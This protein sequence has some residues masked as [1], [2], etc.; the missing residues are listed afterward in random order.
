VSSLG[1]FTHFARIKLI[2]GF[3]FSFFGSLFMFGQM[4]LLMIAFML[5]V[6]GFGL[7]VDATHEILNL[8]SHSSFEYWR[9]IWS[10]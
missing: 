10:M 8:I 7:S 6:S 1:L 2:I 9:D 3:L 5:C 4:P